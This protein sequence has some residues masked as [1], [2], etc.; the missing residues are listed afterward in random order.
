MAEILNT[1][2]IAQLNRIIHSAARHLITA[3]AKVCSMAWVYSFAK[4]VARRRGREVTGNTLASVPMHS[5]ALV[6][7]GHPCRF[8]VRHRIR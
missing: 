3:N 2:M 7:R 1:L 6:V 4:D 5:V 8:L